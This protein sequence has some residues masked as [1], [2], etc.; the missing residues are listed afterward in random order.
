[1]PDQRDQEQDQEND[2]EARRQA[3]RKLTSSSEWSRQRRAVMALEYSESPKARQVLRTLATAQIATPLAE[4]A[5]TA[6]ARLNGSTPAQ[7]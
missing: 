2:E 7:K 4:E 1:M 3:E 6:L 5:Q